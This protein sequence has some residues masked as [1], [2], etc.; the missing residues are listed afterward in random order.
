MAPRWFLGILLAVVE[1][2][3]DCSLRAARDAANGDAAN[4]AWRRLRRAIPRHA[5]AIDDARRRET[6]LAIAARGTLIPTAG[7]PREG[8]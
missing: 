5:N 6:R 1:T 2:G 8:P 7:A 3:G 4:D